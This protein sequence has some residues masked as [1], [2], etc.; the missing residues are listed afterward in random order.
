MRGSKYAFLNKTRLQEAI[1]R[2]GREYRHFRELSPSSEI[3]ALQHQADLSGGVL[4]QDRI[5]LSPRFVDA[6]REK[7]LSRFDADLF[8]ES[9]DTIESIAF[10]CVEECPEACHRSIVA[11]HVAK[12]FGVDVIHLRPC[13]V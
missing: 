11:D 13:V 4:K 7:V 6:Y 10:F 12:Y 9:L 3:R 2:S 1:L 5:T 8:A